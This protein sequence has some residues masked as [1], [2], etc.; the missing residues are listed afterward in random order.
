M[1]HP[2]KSLFGFL[3]S[4]EKQEMTL[5]SYLAAYPAASQAWVL[6]AVGAEHRVPS[7]TLLAWVQGRVSH[8][9]HSTSIPITEAS[10]LGRVSRHDLRPDRYGPRRIIAGK[11]ITYEGLVQ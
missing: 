6:R 4:L 2:Q 5:Q 1:G 11:T 9:A 3:R 7:A 8:P 10:T